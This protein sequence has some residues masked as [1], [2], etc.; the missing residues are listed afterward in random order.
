MFLLRIVADGT[1]LSSDQ[2]HTHYQ[3]PRSSTLY[4]QTLA[5]RTTINRDGGVEDGQFFHPLMSP[6]QA[7]RPVGRTVEIYLD[8]LSKIID[9]YLL[10]NNLT[11]S[12]F[13]RL[14]APLHAS[15][16]FKTDSASS[17]PHSFF[18]AAPNC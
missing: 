12:I 6:R 2:S 7:K 1:S 14:I 11:E 18:F 9:F 16:G 10:Y 13:L 4:P 8:L 3:S 5:D 17:L 15:D